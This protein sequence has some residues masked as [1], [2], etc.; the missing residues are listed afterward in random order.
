MKCLE[1]SDSLSQT[2]SRKPQVVLQ[3]SQICRQVPK[4]SLKARKISSSS[5]STHKIRQV[6]EEILLSLMDSQ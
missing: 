6:K 2:G 1:L 5:N 4:S 3:P